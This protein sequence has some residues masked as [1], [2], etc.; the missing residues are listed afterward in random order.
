MQDNSFEILL[1]SVQAPFPQPVSVAQL[2]G[3]IAHLRTSLN[4]TIEYNI[5][6]HQM[7]GIVIGKESSTLF[8]TAPGI[9]DETIDGLIYVTSW[10]SKTTPLTG[11]KVDQNLPALWQSIAR[12]TTAY[13]SK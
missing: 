12:E 1:Q 5:R 10:D 4:A 13:F 3:L 11:Q 6:D 2:D 8:R 9:A 7:T